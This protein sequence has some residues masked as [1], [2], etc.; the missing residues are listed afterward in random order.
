MP[1][2]AMGLSFCLLL[3]P[4]SGKAAVADAT[5]P[6]STLVRSQAEYAA[7]VRRL[8]PGDRIVLADGIWRDFK[9][10]L[11]GKGRAGSPITLTAQTPGKVILS[12]QSNLSLAG[13]HLL[14]SHLVF[15][16]GWSPTGEVVSFRR[17]RADRA[18]RSRVTG[19]V[20][21]RF[22]KPDRAES[23]HWVALYGHHN[24]FDHNHLVGKNNA[25]ATL[26][27]VRDQEQGL[28]N[29]HRID[30]NWFG[31]RPN[32]GSNGGETLR[33]GTS[34]DSLSDSHTVVEQNWF[35]G[36]DGE[37]EIVSNKSGAN[38]YRGNVFHR[39]RGAL[40]LRHGDG[41]LVED[42]VF[43]G[44]N[45]P[46]HR[47]H[48]RDQSP[49]NGPQQL[50]G[51]TGRR[52]LRLGDHGHVR[53]AGFAVEPLHAGRPCDHRKQHHH[54]CAQRVLRRRQGRRTQRGPGRQQLRA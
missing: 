22:N 50:S 4:I 13:E 33:V 1:F 37:V 8:E 49:A 16:D 26:V 20:I 34:H 38:T 14:V 51:R 15:R 35:E 21:D 27:V 48:P 3:V 32:L 19:V 53:R 25:G 12:G 44:D 11:S 7:A 23:D 17:T 41:N 45:Q 6:G 47:R 31:P 36:C 46:P 54:R 30:R 18:S 28:D 42:N 43:L 29:R 24:R 52:R 39:S 9:I 40:V 2:R 5:A 10:V